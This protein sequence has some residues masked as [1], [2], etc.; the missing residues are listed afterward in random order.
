MQI[1]A[2]RPAITLLTSIAI[3][4]LAGMAGSAVAG[5]RTLVFCSE[6]NPEALNPQIVTTTTGL[7][8][9]RPMFNQLI[10][11][12]PGSTRIRPAL[13]RSW[14]VSADGTEYLIRLRDG[15]QFH[16]TDIFMP[17]RAMNADDVLFSLERQWKEDHPFHNVS[18][19]SYA[20]FKDMGMPDLLETIEKVDDL[21]LKINL[22]RPEAP[23]L[24]NLAMPFNSILSAEYAAQLLAAGTP[25]LLDEKPVGTGP[26]IFDGVQKDV[27]V[28]Y[29]VFPDYWD[30]RQPIERLVFSVTPNPAMGLL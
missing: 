25:E 28:R 2:R 20:Y 12:E 6:G 4:G 24:A 18:E 5:A 13:A 22:T 15:V 3:L 8:A 9:A 7:N 1:I 11:F 29:R 27:A 19:A 26:F 21:T 17:T 16:T 23:F 10:E 30:G 14:E